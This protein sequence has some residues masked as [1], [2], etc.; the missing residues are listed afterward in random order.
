MDAERYDRQL[1]MPQLGPEGQERLA[2]SR[3][4]VVGA[5][6]LGAPAILY[7]AAAG[8][9]TLGIADGDVVELGNL[10]RQV[11]HR[12]EDVGID[13]VASAWRAVAALNPEVNV[14]TY[15][16]RLDVERATDL[17]AQYDL[18][19]DGS[20][21]FASKYAL[22][23]AAVASGRPLVHG[24]VEGMVGQVGLLARPAG[25]CLRCVFPDAPPDPSEPRAI[26]GATAGVLGALQAT[27]ALKHL[28]GLGERHGD[29]LLMV[30]LWRLHFHRV[31]L[32]QNPSCPVCGA[33]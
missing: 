4:L 9:G 26:L 28:A 1:R 7:L 30:N 21:S 10:N 16:E 33:P 32:Q 11:I 8:V 6:G 19:L 17:A 3:V 27:E 24:G 23:D 5:G 18:L 20:D 12:T 25:P 2:Q 29:S 31:T 13:K 14:E 15:S 22:N